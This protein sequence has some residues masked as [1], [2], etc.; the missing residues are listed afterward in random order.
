MR[1]QKVAFVMNELP[2]HRL[3]F[4]ERL[5]RVPGFEIQAVVC[6]QRETRGRLLHLSSAAF[7]RPREK[8]QASPDGQPPGS[9]L[10]VSLLPGGVNRFLHSFQPD[11]IVTNGFHPVQLMAFGQACLRHIPHVAMTEANYAT[12]QSLGRLRHGLR[13]F[14]YARSASFVASS[15]GG[16]RLFESFGIPASR[17]FRS[18]I[19]VD[20]DAYAPRSGAS[21]ERP[22]D[23]IFC[24]QMSEVENPMFVLNVAAETARLLQ[25]KLKVLLVG[26]GELESRVHDGVA[27][28]DELVE[29]EFA[30]FRTAQDR[31]AIYRS[32]RLLLYPALRDQWGVVVNEACAAG[33]PSILTPETGA[34]GELVRYGENG[35]IC[36]LN[37]ATWA[38]HA[39]QLLSDQASWSNFSA[40][41][42]WLVAEYNHDNAVGG[43]ISACRQA[44]AAHHTMQ[45]NKAA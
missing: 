1:V 3:Q 41:C 25:R 27:R 15:M 38:N 37:V 23:L 12:E 43:F 2:A 17:C 26:A 10:Q 7:P 36:Q 8:M 5:M 31:G 45:L 34:A 22:F 32:A 21:E 19:A 39:A 42:R 16:Q 18:C 4:L 11:A 28:R 6:G 29:A 9:L 13:E 30:D 24:G 35:Y 40:R 33:T 20:N 14:V 44:M